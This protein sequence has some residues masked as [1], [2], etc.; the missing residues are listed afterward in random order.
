MDNPPC[1]PIDADAWMLRFKLLRFH[2]RDVPG[3]AD[4]LIGRPLRGGE[5]FAVGRFDVGA[6]HFATA[7][8]DCCHFA[9]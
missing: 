7:L 6:H 3:V 2:F 5:L 8:F 4:P 1:E 9:D